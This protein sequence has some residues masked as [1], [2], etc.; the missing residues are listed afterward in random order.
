MTCVISD[1]HGY[2]I[3]KLKMLLQIL[4]MRRFWRIFFVIVLLDSG[5]VPFLECVQSYHSPEACAMPR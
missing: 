4:K 3:E 1:L 5:E 2:P